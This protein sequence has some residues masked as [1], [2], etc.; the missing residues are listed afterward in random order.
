MDD[1]EIKKTKGRVVKISLVVLCAVLVVVLLLEKNHVKEKHTLEDYTITEAE[2]N[3]LQQEVKSLRQEVNRLKDN[4]AV[5][6]TEKTIS[7][8][9][10]TDT[11]SEIIL[12][13]YSCDYLAYY[14][15]ASFKNNTSSTV[16][17]ISGR[18]IYYDMKGNMLDYRDFT[19]RVEIEPGMVK[20]V[21]LEGYGIN[22]DYSYYQSAHS[23]THP[24]RQYKV[25]FELKN[26]RTK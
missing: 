19:K 5:H 12:A 6:K 11:E 20:S 2:W 3:D 4:K 25:R 18:M 1:F 7:T 8:S 22:E 26:Y 10:D 15:T 16:S 17:Q 9:L 23:Y 13:K 21:E 24:E 14:A